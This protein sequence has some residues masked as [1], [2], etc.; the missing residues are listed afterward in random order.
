MGG[1]DKLIQADIFFFVTTCAIVLLTIIFAIALVYV[2]FIAKNVHYVITKIKD[3]SD[4]I[5]GDIA[6]A[7]QKI[8]EQGVRLLSIFTLLK[9]FAS[10]TSDKKARKKNGKKGDDSEASN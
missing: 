9:S 5:S 7:R 10:F 3:E 8:K 4:N 2:V 1:M 6:S